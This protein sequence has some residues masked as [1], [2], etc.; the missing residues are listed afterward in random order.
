MKPILIDCS[1]TG[2]RGPAKKVYELCTDLK[3]DNIP[4]N[5]LTDTGFATKLR[6]LGIEPDHIVNTRLNDPTETIMNMFHYKIKNIQ[7]EFMVKIG[8]RMA[9]PYV[10]K[11][12]GKPYIIADG[13]LRARV[14]EKQS[15]REARV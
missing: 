5:L 2:G 12:Q 3:Q 4:Y 9:G 11:K 14:V 8:A 7:Y 10:S 15:G 13:G 1:L 6:D